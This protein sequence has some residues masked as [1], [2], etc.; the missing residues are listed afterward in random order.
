[1]AVVL[2]ALF[3]L[4]RF[5]IK[6]DFGAFIFTTIVYIS[7]FINT[8][9]ANQIM[10]IINLLGIPYTMHPTLNTIA[11][12]FFLIAS[13]LA[14]AFCILKIKMLSKLANIT[15]KGLSF[16]L[17]DENGNKVRVRLP[18]VL[19]FLTAALFFILRL[20]Y[21]RFIDIL[22]F[23]G[24]GLFFLNC[25]IS[26]A[27]VAAYICRRHDDK[28][29]TIRAHIAV[30]IVASVMLIMNIVPII[31]FA[32]AQR[33]NEG[34]YKEEFSVDVNP[35]E[36]PNIY[37]I[38]TDGM[39]GFDSMS[40]FFGDDQEWFIEELEN[41]GFFISYEAAFDGNRAT[42]FAL[43]AL[44]NPHYYDRVLSWRFDP[45]YAEANP[46]NDDLLN[47]PGLR[48]IPNTRS[49][50]RAREKNEIVLAFNTA[51]YNTSIIDRIDV[52]FYPTVNQFYSRG[53]LLTTTL[54]VPEIMADVNN[55]SSLRELVNL[56]SMVSPTPESVNL[57]WRG[58]NYFDE[59]I[60]RNFA[61]TETE[62]VIDLFAD[63]QIDDSDISRLQT[64]NRRADSLY[65]ILMR[66][67]PRFVIFNFNMPHRPFYY[68]EF[69]NYDAV[70]ANDPSRYPAH[71][72]FCAKTL[73]KYI[74]LI[75]ESDPDA[76]IVLQA[77]HG[78]HR[79]ERE[80]IME[81]FSVTADEALALWHSVMSAVRIPSEAKTPDTLLVLSDPRNI[82]RYLINNY[83]GQNYDYIPYEF[84]QIFRG[85]DR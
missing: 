64:W 11:L 31:M 80:D 84:R 51:G 67:S 25:A 45:S 73:L 26:L 42:R 49:N 32:T 14:I 54:S 77:D 47:N 55:N 60:T 17:T 46:L 15:W 57:N 52:Y 1:M 62:Q 30:F 53:T 28:L 40:R 66:S 16:K 13:G 18:L 81:M 24:N 58:R 7:F 76:V 70:G 48:L 3:F 61:F 72:K 35:E 69:G 37:W 21:N 8:S 71:H 41:R 9:L 39:L 34:F 38:H 6:S 59:L 4:L 50:R 68:D 65:D 56:L 74:D 44:M 78:L 5:I 85:P 29:R 63:L 23:G 75:L 36:Q 22:H 79:Q 33:T 2:I 19:L 43:P 10:T 20:L 82:S 27:V 12:R 83:V